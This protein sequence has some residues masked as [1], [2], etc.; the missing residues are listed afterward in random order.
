MAQQIRTFGDPVLKSVC[1]PVTVFDQKLADLA[2]DL[3]D[4]TTKI[5]GRAGVAAAAGVVGVRDDETTSFPGVETPL[6]GFMRAVFLAVLAAL[7]AFGAWAI[8]AMINWPL[9]A[10]R[11][12]RVAWNTT[13]S[14][15]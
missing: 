5:S 10:D 15:P 3:L 7:V 9:E 12:V 13:P 14:M 8:W 1:D 4:T 6:V 2:L 11:H